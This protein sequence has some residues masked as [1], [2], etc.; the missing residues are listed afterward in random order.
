[1]GQWDE[2][3]KQ[4]LWESDL[5]ERTNAVRLPV[6]CYASWSQPDER[7]QS[8]HFGKVVLEGEKLTQYCLWRGGLDEN[9]GREWDALLADLKPEEVIGRI[10]SFRFSGEPGNLQ[11]DQ[12]SKS[13]ADFA[14]E[15][16]K[17]GLVEKPAR[18]AA[19]AK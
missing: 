12:P 1:M 17:M 2:K 15:L 7:F 10:D 3:R 14:R 8:E 9:Q 6:D 18:S 11:K 16:I 19:S 5:E 13:Q 4:V